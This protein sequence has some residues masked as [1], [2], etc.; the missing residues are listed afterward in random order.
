MHVRALLLHLHKIGYLTVRFAC[1]KVMQPEGKF[2]DG[3]FLEV[4]L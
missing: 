4:Q 1:A 2:A 3:L